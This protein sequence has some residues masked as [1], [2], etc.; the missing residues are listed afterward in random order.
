MAPDKGRSCLINSLPFAL[1][2]ILAILLPWGCPEPRA[3]SID[4]RILLIGSRGRGCDY[5]ITEETY[6]I[7]NFLEFNGLPYE[8][9]DIGTEV[10][11]QATLDGKEE[12]Y[13]TNDLFLIKRI[14][15]SGWVWEQSIGGAGS[16]WGNSIVHMGGGYYLISGQTES[17]GAGGYDAWLLMMK[18][19]TAGV[20]ASHGQVD[21]PHLGIPGPNPVAASVTVRFSLPEAMSVEVAVYDVSG[22]IVAVL[23]DGHLGAGEHARVWDGRNSEGKRVSPG[24][25]MVQMTTSDFSETRKAVVLK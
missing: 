12:T 20:P 19:P 10:L 21:R 7:E 14:V 9:F 3:E 6:L 15:G 1:V 24:V 17:Y 5:W 25:Y 11:A 18:E 2:L 16:D 22:R 8:L 4:V 23:T 13:Q